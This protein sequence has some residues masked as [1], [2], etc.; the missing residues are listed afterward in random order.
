MAGDEVTIWRGTLYGLGVGP[1]DPELMTIKA[2]KLISRLPVIAYPRP[3]SG[4]SLARRIARPFVPEEAIE[5]E[6]AIPMRIE[7]APARAAY[8]AAAAAI[9]AHLDEGRDVGF[10]CAG[11]P[12]FYGS[13]MYLLE[14]LKGDY[15]TVIVPGVTSLTAAAAA[16]CRPLA[17][18]ADVLKVIPATA[19]MERLESELE[20]ADAAV[21]IKIGR[22]FD[23]V[24]A[25]IERAGLADR[26]F[27]VAAA[28]GRR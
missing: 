20:T 27:I 23:D 2:W 17:A 22:H 1:G 19:G 11:D 9:A 16:A 6:L 21:I 13:F 7:R 12:L 3:D 10:L 14:R 8:D 5:L 26:A 4:E 25:V 24:R 18:R 28:V 15:H